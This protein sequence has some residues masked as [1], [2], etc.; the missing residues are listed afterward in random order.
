MLKIDYKEV[1]NPFILLPLIMLI[2]YFIGVRGISILI[3]SFITF[4]LFS[5]LN[6]LFLVLTNTV[7]KR[8]YL[9]VYFSFMFYSLILIFLFYLINVTHPIWYSFFI[10]G[11]TD[12]I[13]QSY[14]NITNRKDGKEIINKW[15]DKLIKSE[16]VWFHPISLQRYVFKDFTT[17]ITD[18]KAIN[19][20]N[21]HINH[22]HPLQYKRIPKHIYNHQYGGKPAYLF[23]LYL[24]KKENGNG[25]QTIKGL[26]TNKE[27]LI[28]LKKIDNQVSK[29][30]ITAYKQ[31]KN[32]DSK[33]QFIRNESTYK[34]GS[35]NIKIII[36]KSYVKKNPDKIYFFLSKIPANL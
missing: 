3:Y 25:N 4:L 27:L 16:R 29:H 22:L 18:S 24:N 13:I 7:K 20:T 26:K 19:P 34:K 32:K 35:N 36:E 28:K 10:L 14:Y 30:I 21:L 9:Y 6:N 31:G 15:K 23:H 2:H 12:F 11:I 17:T 8:L 1:I 33:G 5:I